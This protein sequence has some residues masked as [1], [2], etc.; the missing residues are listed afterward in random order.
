MKIYNLRKTKGG[1]EMKYNIAKTV[2]YYARISRGLSQDDLAKELNT[3]A[4]TISRY[5]SGIHRPRGK[6]AIKISKILNIPLEKII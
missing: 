3:T 6:T 4:A 5:E 2:I 1:E